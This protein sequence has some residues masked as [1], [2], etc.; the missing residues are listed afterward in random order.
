M[1]KFYVPRKNTT[2]YKWLLSYLI[3]LLIPIVVIGYIYFTKTIFVIDR[4]T[5]EKFKADAKRVSQE[6]DEKFE[7]IRNDKIKIGMNSWLEKVMSYNNAYEKIDIFLVENIMKKLNNYISAN[8]II[9]EMALLFPKSDLV[10]NSRG[11]YTIET[12]F[13]HNAFRKGFL[14]RLNESFNKYTFF[15][16]FPVENVEISANIFNS[17]IRVL[18]IIQS[19]E[20]TSKPPSASFFVL[21]NEKLLTTMINTTVFNSQCKLSLVWDNGYTIGDIDINEFSNIKIKKKPGDMDVEPIWHDNY[22]IYTIRSNIAPWTYV[23]QVPKNIML[24]NGKDIRMYIVISSVLVFIIGFIV[25]AFFTLRNYNPLHRLFTTLKKKIGISR[26]KKKF[27][28]LKIIEE[29]VDKLCRE[30]KISKRKLVRYEPVI[31]AN[32]LMKLTKGYFTSDEQA[33]EILH[34]VGI[35]NERNLLFSV[36]IIEVLKFD[37]NKQD[38]TSGINTYEKL[39]VINILEQW[40]EIKGFNAQVF[41]TDNERITSVLALSNKNISI[42]E[43]TREIRNHI[44]KEIENEI[45]AGCGDWVKR[46]SDINKSFKKAEKMLDWIVFTGDDSHVNMENYMKT[47]NLFYFYP[48]DWEVHIINSLKAGNLES[49]RQ[50]IKDIKYENCIHRRLSFSV[51]KRLLFALVETLMKTMD[52]L[53]IVDVSYEIEFEKIMA[54]KKEGDMWQYIDEKCFDICKSV[55]S[56][57]MNPNSVLKKRILNYVK[58]NYYNSSMSLKE[59]SEKFNIPSSSLSRMFKEVAGVNFLEYVNKKRIEKAKDYLKDTNR[60]IKSISNIVGYDSDKTFRRI[61][62][63]YEG[64]TPVEYRSSIIK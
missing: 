48:P 40:F 42:L 29:S 38:D 26:E 61:F 53:N 57:R 36:I 63:K 39:G 14:E 37:R 64:I 11:R 34:E 27:S 25:S 1:K 17:P 15:K 7:K 18:P 46:A 33:K 51:L 43:I 28:E 13:T 35:E 49:A 5:E 45:Y 44:K 47:D 23:Y 41:E 6:I 60:H 55:E 20:V 22:C 52:E 54:C 12:Y 16:V 62:K 10:L 9:D 8:R 32:K 59:L 3:V 31:R 50:V 56:K 4:Q 19:M 24:Y 21:V 30:N 58:Y 2:F